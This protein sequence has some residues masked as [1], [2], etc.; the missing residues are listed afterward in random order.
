MSR[1]PG[2]WGSPSVCLSEG[3]CCQLESLGHSAKCLCRRHRR[4]QLGP[5]Q[6]K[7]RRR[8][9]WLWR[10]ASHRHFQVSGSS[11]RRQDNGNTLLK[12]TWEDAFEDSAQHQDGGHPC[13][14]GPCWEFSPSRPL[15]D[16]DTCPHGTLAQAR[17]GWLLPGHE[18]DASGAWAACWL[19]GS[20]NNAQAKGCVG[21]GRDS[22]ALSRQSPGPSANGDSGCQPEDW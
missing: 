2:S 10:M 21:R 1:Q 15:A 4:M 9:S 20:P 7:V 14:V 5:A 8:G 17:A 18:L 13:P 22:Q 12:G 11:S 6:G 19:Q 3:L 16:R